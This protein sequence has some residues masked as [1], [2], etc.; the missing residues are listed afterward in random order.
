VRA[1][2]KEQIGFDMKGLTGM[3]CNR[4]KIRELLD[5]KRVVRR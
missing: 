2:E 5:M 1:V 3:E 4:E